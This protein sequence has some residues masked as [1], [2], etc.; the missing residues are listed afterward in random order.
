MEQLLSLQE[1]AKLLAVSER[2]IF[3]LLERKE[4][5]GI[6]VGNRWRFEP[7]EVERYLHQQRQHGSVA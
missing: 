6:K 4:L 5:V 1:V 7:H 3:N 2:T